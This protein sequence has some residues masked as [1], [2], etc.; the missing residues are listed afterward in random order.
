M[1]LFNGKLCVVIVQ[2]GDNGADEN[3]RFVDELFRTSTRFISDILPL[4]LLIMS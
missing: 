3:K 4:H 2:Y 1:W